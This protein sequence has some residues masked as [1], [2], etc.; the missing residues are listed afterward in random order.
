VATLMMA[1]PIQD[2]QADAARAF[3]QECVGPRYADYDASER[4]IGIPVENWY[5]LRVAGHDAFVIQVE[6]SDLQASL[7]AFIG[8]QEP[9]DRWFKEQ[10]RAFTGIDLNAGP[11][12]AETMAETLAEYNVGRA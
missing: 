4:R 2:G 12:P 3:A 9:F 7:G 8:S 11:P 5:L 6:G 10:V 1:L